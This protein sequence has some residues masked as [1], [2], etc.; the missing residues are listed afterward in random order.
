MIISAGETVSWGVE[1]G[2]E[3]TAVYASKKADKYK[4]KIPEVQVPANIDPRLQM[5]V[6]Y[7]RKGTKVAVKVSGYLSW[8]SLLVPF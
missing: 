3:K 6:H 4:Q 7:L 1:K 2:A 8:L 5:S